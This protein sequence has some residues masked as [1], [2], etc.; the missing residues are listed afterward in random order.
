VETASKTEVSRP[1]VD[2]LRGQSEP[3]TDHQDCREQTALASNGRQH[4]PRWNDTI[5]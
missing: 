1:L 2:M 3:Y 5:T 4:H